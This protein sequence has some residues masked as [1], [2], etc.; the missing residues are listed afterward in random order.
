VIARLSHLLR[1][2]VRQHQQ[3][4]I[5]HLVFRV[6]L[7]ELSGW[8]AG[9]RGAETDFMDQP[10]AVQPDLQT[11]AVTSAEDLL[12]EGPVITDGQSQVQ[13]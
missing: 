2:H 7:G 13:A 5:L 8:C 6:R 1:S 3:V 11:P 12:L 9:P 4:G 10:A